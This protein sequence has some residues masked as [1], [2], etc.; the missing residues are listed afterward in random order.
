MTETSLVVKNIKGKMELGRGKES[1]KTTETKVYQKY[2]DSAATLKTP[3][4]LG[5]HRERCVSFAL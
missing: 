4:N 1:K 3:D 5:S 2:N